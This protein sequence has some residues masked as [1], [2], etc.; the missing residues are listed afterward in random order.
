MFWRFVFRCIALLINGK[1][2]GGSAL[3]N[4]GQLE[5]FSVKK[6]KKAWHQHK[7]PGWSY[8]WLGMIHMTNDIVG[9]RLIGAL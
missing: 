5:L 6:R 7:I 1:R 4:N 2:L 3:G 9:A 8:L